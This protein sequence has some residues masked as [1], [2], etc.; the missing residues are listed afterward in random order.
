MSYSRMKSFFP[1]LLT[2]PMQFAINA[3]RA[4]GFDFI[5]FWEVALIPPAFRPFRMY[6]H[7]GERG[8]LTYREY[9]VCRY[10]FWIYLRLDMLETPFGWQKHVDLETFRVCVQCNKFVSNKIGNGFTQCRCGR[11]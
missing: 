4:I 3:G 5:R 11:G 6:S 8:A 9:N 10:G 7:Y 1:G 2:V